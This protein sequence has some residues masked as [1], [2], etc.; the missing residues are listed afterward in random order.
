MPP[1]ARSVRQ[2]Q[3]EL[4]A[5][6]RDQGKTWPEV[7]AAFCEHYGVN[8]RAAL[9]MARDW[10]QRDAADEWN[11][12][13]P[14][15][16]KTYKNFYYWERWPR[17][18]GP[19]PSLDALARLAELYECSMADLLANCADFRSAD[20][21]HRDSRQ[22]AHL[23]AM[24]NLDQQADDDAKLH[25]LIS[26]LELI[27]VHELARL[28]AGWSRQLGNGLNRRAALLKLS[29]ALSIAAA[30]PAIADEVEG[31]ELPTTATPD[32]D[33]SGIWHSAYVYTSTRRDKDFVGE[34]YV[35]F[36]HVGDRLF[37]ESLPA[38][39]GS[40]LRL[41]LALN[42]SVATGTW[43]ERTSPGGYYRGSV[44][45][46]AIQLVIDPMGKTMRGRWVGF[47][48]EFTVD[49]NKWEL[50]WVEQS[51]AKSAQRPYHFKA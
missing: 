25:D 32:D 19:A 12:R 24:V 47:D 40:R 21:A 18:N 34:H 26:R 1:A 50:H 51:L 48:R 46:G 39:N 33:L 42:G 28:S 37:G 36:R 6:L 35:M 20:A 17:L 43:S 23:A 16:L 3:R 30:S 44:Y 22:L 29:A 11:R 15:E 8:M 41:D 38:S 7:A 9:R 5:K 4:A 13:W 10:S 14:A 27:D 2:E 45:H 49:S 31:G